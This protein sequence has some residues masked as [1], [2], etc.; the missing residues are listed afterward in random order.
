MLE[1]KQIKKIRELRE[2]EI[3]VKD[4]A[5]A[6]G[7]SESSVKKYLSDDYEKDNKKD[8]KTGKTLTD[9]MIEELDFEDGVIPL[10][11]KL[12]NQANEIDVNLF[13]Y[14][15][16]ISNTM[17]KFL[18][19][20]CKP[21][22]FYYVFMEIANNLAVIITNNIDANDLM[23]AI[24]NWYNRELELEQAEIYLLETQE[25]AETIINNIKEEQTFFE[26]ECKNKIKELE[27]SN[28][29]IET[30]AERLLN[31]T[32][33]ELKELK[34]EIDN[35]IK[36]RENLTTLNTT[37]IKKIQEKINLQKTEGS[38]ADKE[39]QELKQQLSAFNIVFDK[40]SKLFPNEIAVI[41]QEIDNERQ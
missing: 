1:E 4:I 23:N 39:N 5:K 9:L 41:I 34:E 24:D 31:N 16:D 26:E 33:E 40:I 11:Y 22:W 21:E 3:T 17:S 12:K 20:T 36:T 37:I 14:L 28:N 27:I 32:K 15:T 8:E 19:I 25:K 10:V 18:R 6:V 2:K 38:K 30:K 29:T 7:V 35:A 13:D